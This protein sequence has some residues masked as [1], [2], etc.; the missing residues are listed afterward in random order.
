MRILDWLFGRKKNTTSE[1]PYVPTKRK[2][3]ISPV[4]QHKRQQWS[5]PTDDTFQPGECMS[6]V[7]SRSD[8]KQGDVIR[9][10]HD[11]FQEWIPGWWCEVIRVTDGEVYLK[12]LKTG[13]ETDRSWEDTLGPAWKHPNPER[14]KAIG[15]KK[16][17]N[18]RTR[19]SDLRG[20]YEGVDFI[21]QSESEMIHILIQLIYAYAQN[22]KDNIVKLEPAATKIGDELNRRGGISEMRRV[23]NQLPKRT[24]LRTLEMH[25]H[26]IGEWRG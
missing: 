19:M 18:Y 5:P 8:L 20:Y 9:I 10:W 6:K 22:D 13:E 25:W 15:G 12:D 7:S 3:E 16:S 21:K 26:G 1:R 17:E 11:Y 14:V 2:S 4:G 23:F 24:G